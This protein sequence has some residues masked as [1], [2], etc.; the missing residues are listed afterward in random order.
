MK[1]NRRRIE[2]PVFKITKYTVRLKGKENNQRSYRYHAKVQRWPC[3]A[4]S[5]PIRGLLRHSC[6]FSHRKLEPVFKIF[7]N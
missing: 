5:L 3:S 7:Q 2:D 6:Q 4:P 1:L